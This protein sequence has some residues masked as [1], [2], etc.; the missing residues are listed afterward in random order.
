MAA[1]RYIVRDVDSSVEFFVSQLGFK[2]EQ[3]FGPA[4]A[5]LSGHGVELWLAGPPASASQPMPDGSKPGPGGW[6]RLVLIVDD[7]NATVDRLR[8]AGT[9][10]RNEVF[11]GPGGSQILCEDPSGNP[12]EIFQPAG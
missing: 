11:T 6:N 4:I 2:L 7:I 12:I 9:K 3:Q 1:F 10:F 8:S 5:I